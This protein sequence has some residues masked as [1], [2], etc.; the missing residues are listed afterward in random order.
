MQN[1]IPT[2][3]A[4][5]LITAL[6]KRGIE[7]KSEYSDGHKHVDLY[8]PEAKIY[9]EIDGLQHYTDPKLF[10]ADLFRDHYSNN[11]KIFTKHISNQLIETHLEEIADA[12]AQIVK[13]RLIK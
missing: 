7:I 6:K 10:V 9:I 13:E 1:N 12:I 3:Q 2:K 5:N 4:L 11:D 8:I